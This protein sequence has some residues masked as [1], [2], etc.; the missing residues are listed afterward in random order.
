MSRCNANFSHQHKLNYDGGE[1][2]VQA[3]AFN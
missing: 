1:E 3:N 2:D